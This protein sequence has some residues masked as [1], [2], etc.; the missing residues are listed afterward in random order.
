MMGVDMKKPAEHLHNEKG[1]AVLESVILLFIFLVLTRYTIGFFGV[2]HTAIL[3]SI[4]SRNYAFEIFR[5]RSHLWYFRDNR[6]MVPNLRYHNYDSRI[7]GTNNELAVGGIKNQFPTE[8]RIAMFIEEEPSG[9]TPNEHASATSEVRP[10][11]RNSSVSLDPV[12]IK[13]Q[14]GICLTVQCGD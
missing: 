2:T 6:P 13:A 4:A 14:Y 9:R 1:L 11:E 8:R 5:H 12:W 7:H 3:Q 10:G